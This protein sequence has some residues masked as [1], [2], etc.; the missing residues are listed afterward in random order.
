MKKDVKPL[1]IDDILGR[2]LPG[3]MLDNEGITDEYLVKKLKE[4]LEGDD[5]KIRQAARKDAHSLKG[6]YRPE[7]KGDVFMQI[8]HQQNNVFMSPV[9]K[10]LLDTHHR[11]LLGGVIEG[12]IVEEKERQR[13]VRG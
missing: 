7:I 9:V 1:T 6:H 11:M 10:E 3:E 4:E 8:I 5:L 2:P 12:E 13:D